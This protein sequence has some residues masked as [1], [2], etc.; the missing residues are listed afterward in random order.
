[1]EELGGD[2]EEGREGC[3]EDSRPSRREEL[4]SV[5]DRTCCSS[6][7]MLWMRAEMEWLVELKGGGVIER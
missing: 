6:F 3:L 7:C 4:T 5:M 1:M 2:E